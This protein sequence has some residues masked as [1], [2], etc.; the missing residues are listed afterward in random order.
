MIHA[1]PADRQRIE[2]RKRAARQQVCAT[3]G[4]WYWRMQNSDWTRSPQS[5]SV[6]EDTEQQKR[7]A[8]ATTTTTTRSQAYATRLQLD[9]GRCERA[10]EKPKR[11]TRNEN[12]KAATK[13]PLKTRHKRI[14]YAL[15]NHLEIAVSGSMAKQG[16]HSRMIFRIDFEQTDRWDREYKMKHV[17]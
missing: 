13:Q 8:A 2:Q 4:P 15:T 6:V 10:T 17:H 12:S 3:I 5:S 7:A 14:I 11:I 9:L 1:S 16:K